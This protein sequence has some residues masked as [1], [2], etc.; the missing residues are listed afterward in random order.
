MACDKPLV[1]ISSLDALV[2]PLGGF[3]DPVCA[4]ID[5]RKNEV[6]ACWYRFV[7]GV[8]EKQTQETVLSP[9]TAA[10]RENGSCLFVGTG[11]GVYREVILKVTA[12]RARFAPSFQND[13]NPEVVAHLAIQGFREDQT[14]SPDDFAPVY[15]RPPDAVAARPAGPVDNS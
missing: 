1:G 15:I 2:F 11:A 3:S 5:A 7:N 8:M 4:L 9:E 10:A 14:V 13:I 6:Y 12:G